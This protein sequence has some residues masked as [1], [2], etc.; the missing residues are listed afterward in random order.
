MESVPILDLA[1]V[2]LGAMG[3]AAAWQAARRGARVLGIEQY[4]SP[5]ALGSSHGD[6]RITRLAIGEGDRYTPLVLR[7]NEIW[8]EIESETGES[9]HVVTGGIIISGPARSATTHVP[10]FFENTLAA[11]RRFHVAHEILDA[12]QIRA[13]FP[14][15]EVRDDE[16]GYYEPG[17]GYLKPERCIAAQLELARRAGAQL[18]MGE[19]VVSIEDHGDVVEVV[20]DRA[21]YGARQVILSMG[22]WLPQFLEPAQSKR[23]AVTRQV[24]Y[25]FQPRGAIADYE[26]PR[27]PVWIWELRESKHVIYGFPAI[28]GAGGGVKLATEQFAATTTPQSVDREVSDAEKRAMHRDLVAPYLPGLGPH[29]VK[30]VACMYTST[31]DAQ[32]WIDRDP[33][34]RNVFIVSACS[35]HGFKHSAAIGEELALRTFKGG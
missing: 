19:R 34:R 6:T 35:G 27:F 5:H 21:T 4:E 10:D 30:A 12:G 8:R 7:A 3:S 1:V 17:A 26:A 18:H 2:G 11:A 33:A 29:C 14:Q 16:V 9:L 31:P 24:L 28:D 22:A 23:L 13:R 20:T 25:W 15:F 32:F